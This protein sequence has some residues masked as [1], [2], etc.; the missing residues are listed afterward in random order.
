MPSI[1]NSQLSLHRDIELKM[2]HTRPSDLF[3]TINNLNEHLNLLLQQGRVIHD[4]SQ[5]VS[6]NNIHP[7]G[8]DLQGRDDKTTIPPSYRRSR[9]AALCNGM[10]VTGKP[11]LASRSA[12]AKR[13][14]SPIDPGRLNSIASQIGTWNPGQFTGLYH[15]WHSQR[16]IH[17]DARLY[18]DCGFLRAVFSATPSTTPCSRQS[19]NRPYDYI[20]LQGREL[21]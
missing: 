13:T 5:N 14:L 4:N 15:L 20:V 2:L 11:S 19:I 17:T 10:P 8:V 9:S 3:M 6:V 18:R 12:V 1:W 16:C 7:L 21:F